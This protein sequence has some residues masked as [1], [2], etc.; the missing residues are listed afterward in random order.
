MRSWSSSSFII[1][2]SRE[3]VML[4]AGKDHPLEPVEIEQP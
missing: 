3:V 1:A 2:S 4:D